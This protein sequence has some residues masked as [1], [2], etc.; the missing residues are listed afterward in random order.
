MIQFCAYIHITNPDNRSLLENIIYSTFDMP[1][2]EW[3]NDYIGKL[4]VNNEEAFQLKLEKLHYLIFSDFNILASFLIV[5]CFNNIFLPYLK[6]LNVEV[7]T[8]FEIFLRHIHHKQ[9]TND[10]YKFKNLISKDNLDTIKEYF[11]CNGNANAVAE[12]LFLHK[13]SY[14]YRIKRFTSD[15]NLNYNDLNTLLFIKL[16]LSITE[17]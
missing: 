2:V 17:Y 13:N 12:E 14:A 7:C 6:K 10:A 11:K 16:I 4:S 3:I 15:T 9:V 8:A 1:N 5:P